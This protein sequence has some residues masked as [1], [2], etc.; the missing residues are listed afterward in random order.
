MLETPIWKW[1]AL[2]ITSAIVL[3][4]FHAVGGIFLLVMRRV[5]N[6]TALNTRWLFIES[7]LQPLLVFL[8]AVAFVVVEQYIDPSALSRLYIGRAILLVVVWSVSWCPAEFG[9]YVPIPAG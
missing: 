5:S 9:R 7:L 2:I 6:T 8:A 1:I 4:L 3:F